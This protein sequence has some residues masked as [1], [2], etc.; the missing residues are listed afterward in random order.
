MT[1]PGAFPTADTFDKLYRGEPS[2]EGGPKPAGIPWDVHQGQPGLFELEALG[3]IT[4]EV[5]DIGCGLGDNSIFLASRGYSVT[6]LDGSRVAIQQA[7][8]PAARAGGT[9]GL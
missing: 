8:G 4:G 2:F 9:G 3:R 7:R 5:L 1:S 6:G